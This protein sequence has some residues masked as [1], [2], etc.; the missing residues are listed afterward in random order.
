MF[1]AEEVLMHIYW[2]D[3]SGKLVHGNLK[4]IHKK[5]TKTWSHGPL[6][7]CNTKASDVKFLSSGT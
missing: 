6:V 5:N 3:L 1:S 2:K 7:A 4:E